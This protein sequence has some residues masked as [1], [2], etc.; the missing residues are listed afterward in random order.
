MRRKVI[1]AA[2]V[3]LVPQSHPRALLGSLFLTEAQ[4]HSYTTTWTTVC[5]CDVVLVIQGCL[6]CFTIADRGY[7]QFATAIN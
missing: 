3:R 7:L 4:P 1:N 6:Q 5:R 2:H